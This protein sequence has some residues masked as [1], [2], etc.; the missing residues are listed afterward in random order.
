MKNPP[1]IKVSAQPQRSAFRVRKSL[2]GES[3]LS[4]Q[5]NSR[6]SQLAAAP[7]TSHIVSRTSNQ[8]QHI[9]QLNQTFKATFGRKRHKSRSI[10]VKNS[11]G[12]YGKPD[13]KFICN[14]EP[15]DSNLKHSYFKEDRRGKLE[16]LANALVKLT[17]T[18]EGCST[19]LW[20]DH[21]QMA[22]M[23]L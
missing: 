13:I 17:G 6:A 15:D 22:P 23:R 20:K 9:K 21:Q 16:H 18:T 3:K 11:Y 12:L 1:D 5:A 8:K 10:F 14:M 19:A 2:S 7:S 4:P